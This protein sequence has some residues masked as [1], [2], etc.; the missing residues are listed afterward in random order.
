MQPAAGFE[1]QAEPVLA[2]VGIFPAEQALAGPGR[3]STVRKTTNRLPVDGH[4]ARKFQQCLA[5][6]P[7]HGPG[8]AVDRRRSSS[9]GRVPGSTGLASAGKPARL[10]QS[11]TRPSRVGDE[12]RIIGPKAD[13]AGASPAACS[14]GE[15]ASALRL[16]C[17]QRGELLLQARPRTS[18]AASR[19]AFRPPR[20]AG[21][22]ADRSTAAPRPGRDSRR[23]RPATSRRAR[24]A[25]PSRPASG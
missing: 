16:A 19:R 17:D 10:G 4:S 12:V 11:M 24:S 1:H 20:R 2:G 14:L 5:V 6:E 7:E 22:G 3:V 21:S 8:V 23:T 15:L 13:Q 18:R 9:A 25:L